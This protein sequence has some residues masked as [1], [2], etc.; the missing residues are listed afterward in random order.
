VVLMPPG[1]DIDHFDWEPPQD[2]GTGRVLYAGR[3]SAGRGVRLLL[4]AIEQVK[5]H[6]PVKLMLAGHVD[7]GFQ[8]LLDEAIGAA[9]LADDVEQVGAIEHDDMPRVIAQAAVCVAPASPDER[10]RPLA[11]F[12]TKLLEY[13]AC[14]RA[15]V[16]PRRP[17]VEELIDDGVQGLL[18]TPGSAGDLARA[19]GKLLDDGPLREVLAE[20]GYERVRDEQPASATR[21][22]LLEAY[23]RLLPSAAWAPPGRAGETVDGLPSHPDTTTARRPLAT[24]AGRA[25]GEKSGE[26]VISRPP[27]DP[28]VKPGE[29][30][31]EAIDFAAAGE[32]RDTATAMA[33]AAPSHAVEVRE[34]PS[35]GPISIADSFGDELNT[36]L[37]VR[38]PVP[39]E[40]PEIPDFIAEGGLL[41]ASPTLADAP[42]AP[43]AP[44][45]AENE[46]TRPGPLR[47]RKASS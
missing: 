9:G 7:E 32:A 3:I 41:G 20:S 34:R 39:D 30:V 27:H 21:R 29:V 5:K 36:S 2:D 35:D 18:F 33:A 26:I 10:D 45:A 12:P 22:R 31:I 23:A 25:L 44:D 42:D 43:D 11:G 37:Y 46:K 19:I 1:V 14:R 6:R 15:V 8:T 24:I 4:Q 16:A 17:S 38:S 28:E 40:I 47:P 13:M